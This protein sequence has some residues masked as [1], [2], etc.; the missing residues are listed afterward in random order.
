[1]KEARYEKTWQQLG[2]D[3]H[4]SFHRY[5]DGSVF[6]SF[7]AEGANLSIHLSSED[8]KLLAGEFNA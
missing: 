3:R 6:L 4:Y 7:D 1:M 2:R 5:V 8:A